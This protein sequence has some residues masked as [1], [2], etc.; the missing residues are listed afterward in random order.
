[1]ML[2]CQ[3]RLVFEGVEDDAGEGSF[4]ATD[5]LAAAFAFGL[6]AFEVGACG[7]MET[8]LG[9]RN[10]TIYSTSSDSSTQ[11]TSAQ[12]SRIG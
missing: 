7:R 6:F 5:C 4:E 10:P 8:R 3:E 9:D 11:G 12:Q 2:L 1:M